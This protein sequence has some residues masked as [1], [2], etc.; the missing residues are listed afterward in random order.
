MSLI[1]EQIKQRTISDNNLLDKS[2]KNLAYSISNDKKY[3][4]NKF[5]SK[6]LFQ[7]NI[8][9]L[10]SYYKCSYEFSNSFSEIV[11]DKKA[12]L[13]DCIDN[14]GLKK[15]EIALKSNWHK[16]SIEPIFAFTLSGESIVFLPKSTGGY[17]Y[18]DYTKCRNITVNNKNCPKNI[19]S[20]Y[21]F[22][23]TF[24]NKII[25][26]KELFKNILSVISISNWLIISIASIL[27]AIIGLTTPYGAMLIFDYIIP[28]KKISPLLIIALFLFI[29][30]IASTIL[31]Y[32]KNIYISRIDA[33]A[34]VYISSAIADRMTK[35]HCSFFIKNSTGKISNMIDISKEFVSTLI[36]T[37]PNF[38]TEILICL[39]AIIETIILA[40]QLFVPLI[41]SLFVQFILL[42]ILYF[43]TQKQIS[44]SYNYRSKMSAFT[45]SILSSLTKI[46]LANAEKRFFARFLKI[47][48]KYMLNIVHPPLFT[49][50]AIP[51]STLI[52]GISLACFFVIASKTDIPLATLIAFYTIWG[53]ISITLL[54]LFST[55]INMAYLKPMY[56]SFKPILDEESE[57]NQQ[58]IKVKRLNGSIEISN[59]SYKYDNEQQIF[60]KLSLNVKRGDYIGITGTSGCG[61]STLIK[62]L[63]GMVKPQS[64]NIFYDGIDINHLNLS[65]LRKNIGIVLQSSTLFNGDI[66]SNITMF[67]PD[68]TIND[69]WEA[70]E[71]A[72]IADDIRKMPM[73]IH[74]LI[75]EGGSNLSGGQ[76][77]KIIIARALVTKPRLLIFDEA[78]SSL[79]NISQQKISDA[80]DNMKCTRII[81]AHRL[82]T[83][84]FCKRIVVL[85]N[86]IVAEDG[87]FDE[88]LQKNGIFAQLI[89]EQLS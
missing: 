14:A 1:N 72:D 79:D 36:N 12:I 6:E 44:S 86:G 37:I 51:L 31:T 24:G 82:S 48:N 35:I 49:I 75:A 52:S 76:K 2:I 33:K 29:S 25:T 87:T 11:E 7:K 4:Q 41:I 66:L 47:Y 54:K 9:S 28:S 16:T 83:L 26:L 56:N 13:F 55:I 77:Q 59:V 15:R 27:S 70:A 63:L 69:A 40:K 67:S 81:V 39:I 42:V 21:C 8:L 84:K 45:M 60:K 89:K 34:S 50:I 3:I 78:T 68:I 85:D 22:Y 88:L 57:I 19:A 64:G 65:S 71:I 17:Y 58:K 20:A 38:I 46:R 80:I 18:Y 5:T 62:L 32:I 30:C 74:T 23:R 61:K 10:L 73:G 43:S 53:I